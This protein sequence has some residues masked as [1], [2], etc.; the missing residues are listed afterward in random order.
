MLSRGCS[1]V[2]KVESKCL[3]NTD[4]YWTTAQKPTHPNCV[5]SASYNPESA[6]DVRP[7]PPSAVERTL[8]VERNVD[9]S[10][11]DHYQI[12]KQSGGRGELMSLTLATESITALL[13]E[14][15][16]WQFAAK[17]RNHVRRSR[18]GF[19]NLQHANFAAMFSSDKIVTSRLCHVLRTELVHFRKPEFAMP[20]QKTKVTGT[21]SERIK[22]GLWWHMF[23][24]K[25]WSVGQPRGFPARGTVW[26]T[27]NLKFIFRC[28]SP[29]ACLVYTGE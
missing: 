21:Q 11:L 23:G 26:T 3:W 18:S 29:E 7:R 27:I 14:M 6:W 16:G 25:Y 28:C 15:C 2:W 17:P 24:K 8:S 9:S 1:K 20:I 19:F 22:V 5:I 13:E 12:G 10:R 4:R